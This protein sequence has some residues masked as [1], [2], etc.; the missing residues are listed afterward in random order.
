MTKP[1]KIAIFISGRGSNMMSLLEACKAA[2]FPASPVLVISNRSDAPGLQAAQQAG[3]T[4][5]TL[6]RSEFPSPATYD[7]ALNEVLN[8]HEVELVCLAGFMQILSKQFVEKWHDRIL[9]IHPSLLPSFKGLNVHERALAAGVKF[10]GCTVHFVRYEMDTGPIIAQA[11]VPVKEDDTADSLAARVLTEEH[12][13]YPQALKL[14]A[15]G[16]L[17]GDQKEKPV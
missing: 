7:I 4:T 10:T 13:I 14:V 8:E 3:I 16:A 1:V 9:N 6:M 11:V 2:D 12:R 5:A 15:S 17:N